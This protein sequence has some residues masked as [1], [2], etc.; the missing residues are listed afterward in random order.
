MQNTHV[1]MIKPAPPGAGVSLDN[2]QKTIGLGA[3]A[4][5]I[6]EFSWGSYKTLCEF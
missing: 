4:G 6:M 3:G 1:S 5:Y 2:P